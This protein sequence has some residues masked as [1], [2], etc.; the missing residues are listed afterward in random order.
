MEPVLI[1]RIKQMMQIRNITQA[2]L[3]RITGIRASSISDYL[4]G[5]YQPKQD[6]IALIAD[7]LSVNPGWLMGY[8]EPKKPVSS[9]I[10]EKKGNWDLLAHYQKLSENE[11][12]TIATMIKNGIQDF[13]VKHDTDNLKMTRELLSLFNQLDIED[14]IEIKG[15]IK[16]MLKADKYKVKSNDEAI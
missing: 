8:D 16:G 6:K 7:A 13:T 2:D 10:V 3:A 1:Q 11:Q 4:S 14:Q 12:K 15:E 5:K 9:S